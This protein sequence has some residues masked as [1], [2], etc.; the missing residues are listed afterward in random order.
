MVRPVIPDNRPNFNRRRRVNVLIHGRNRARIAA[1]RLL[2]N[3]TGGIRRMSCTTFRIST[4]FDNDVWYSPP[5]EFIV[6]PSCGPLALPLPPSALMTNQSSRQLKYIVVIY[7]L[8]TCSEHSAVLSN[9]C[10]SG[11]RE[12]DLEEISIDQSH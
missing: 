7:I 6:R 11:T 9:I 3:A 2:R 8:H 1:I 12:F 5:C 10:S 4:N